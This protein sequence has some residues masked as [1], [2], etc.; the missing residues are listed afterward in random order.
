MA[1]KK[2]EGEMTVKKSIWPLVSCEGANK[3]HEPL[4]RPRIMN[5]NADLLGTHALL[6]GYNN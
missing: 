1:E 2:I 6:F 5:Q 4:L 3:G